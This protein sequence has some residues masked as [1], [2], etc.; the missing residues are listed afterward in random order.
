[1]LKSNRQTILERARDVLWRSMNDTANDAVIDT[2]DSIG[3]DYPPASY[4]MEPPHRRTGNLQ[5]G[6]SQTTRFDGAMAVASTVSSE[7]ADGDP[8]VPVWLEWGT[9]K[10]FPRPFASPM[11]EKWTPIFKQRATDALRGLS[12]K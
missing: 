6:I 7:R 5:D 4:A 3:I 12:G 9:S 2:K 11:K 1:M 8:M 10:L